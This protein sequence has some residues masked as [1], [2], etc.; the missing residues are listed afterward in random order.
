MAL[1]PGYTSLASWVNDVF[2]K[3]LEKCHDMETFEQYWAQFTA[4]QKTAI[5]NL[6]TTALTEHKTSVDAIIAHIGTL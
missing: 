3:A 5:K 6:V 1:P 4:G 2:S